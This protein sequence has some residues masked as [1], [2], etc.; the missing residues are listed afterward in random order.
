MTEEQLKNAN[1]IKSRRDHLIFF[2]D[3]IL[4]Y[5]EE[6]DV[7]GFKSGRE[8]LCKIQSI[9]HHLLSRFCNKYCDVE[10]APLLAPDISDPDGRE[11]Y[12]DLCAVA[13]KWIKIYDERLKEL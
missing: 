2:K 5:M 10:K 12:K 3:N 13:D 4:E 11:L 8:Q 1:K 9:W 7:S 6:S